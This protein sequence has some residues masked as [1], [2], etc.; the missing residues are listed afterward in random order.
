MENYI[1]RTCGTQYAAVMTHLDSCTICE[2][3]RQFVLVSRAWL[4]RQDQ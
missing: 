4:A 3:L 1:C 2:D